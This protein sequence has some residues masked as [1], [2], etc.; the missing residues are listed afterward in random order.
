MIPTTLAT[1]SRNE[2]KLNA[3][4]RP[5]RRRRIMPHSAKNL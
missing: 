5:R 1:T 3:I 2:S 4:S